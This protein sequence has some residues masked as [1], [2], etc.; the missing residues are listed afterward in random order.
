MQLT[1]DAFEAD[2]QDWLVHLFPRRQMSRAEYQAFVVANPDLRIER[3]AHGEV[4]VMP[5]AHS[6]VGYQN[7]ELTGQL[8]NWARQDGRGVAFDSSAGFDLPNGAI[9]S[10]DAAWVLKSRLSSLTPAE[11]AEYLPLCPDF[12]VELRSR[13]DRL[14][15]VQ[16]KMREYV[17]NGARLGWLIDP[18]E[19]K[20]QVY[21]PGSPPEV[22]ADP[23]SLAGDPE[24]PG[25]IVDL[26]YVW[27]PEV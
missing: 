21:R 14:S 10:P 22:L 7:S 2:S 20:V 4:I 8:R 13:S 27:N 24:M 6:R 11:R 23:A 9:R 19:R 16:A 18:L 12:V 5:A 1:L 17:D 15:M 26:T 3:T 25:L